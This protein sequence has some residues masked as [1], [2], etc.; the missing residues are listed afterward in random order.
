[1]SRAAELKNIPIWAFHNVDDAGT[2][3]DG[4]KATVAAVNMAGGNARLTFPRSSDDK[5]DS[6]SAAFRKYNIVSWMLAQHRGGL[7]WCPPGC[8]PWKWRH[9]L[10]MPAAFLAVSW[11]AWSRAKRKHRRRQPL[12]VAD[13]PQSSDDEGDFILCLPE[14]VQPVQKE[15][16][17]G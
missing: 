10:A 15:D 13:H 6:W 4:D 8:R 7:C 9:I 12:M 3:S 11:L 17:G 2:P 14:E 5:H 1:V 16:N